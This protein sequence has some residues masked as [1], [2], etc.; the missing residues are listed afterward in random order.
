MTRFARWRRTSST[1]WPTSR[2]RLTLSGGS[3]DSGDGSASTET[4]PSPGRPHSLGIAV[5][6]SVAVVVIDG[7]RRSE[8]TA[9]KEAETNFD[10][11]QRAVEVYLTNVSENTLLKEQDSVDIRTLRRDLLKSA[12]E[13]YKEFADQRKNDPSLRKQ[14]ANAYFRV[15]QLTRE[16]GSAPL[17]IDALRSAQ[18]IWE[19]LVEGQPKRPRAGRPSGRLLPGDRQNPVGARRLPRGHAHARPVA[20]DPGTTGRAPPVRSRLTDR[21]SPTVTSRSASCMP[22]SDQPEESLAIHEKARAIQQDLIS[23]FPDRLSY[24]R[25]LAENINA[26]GYAHYRRLDYDAALRA[27]HAVVDA[28]QSIMKQQT[29]GPNAVWLLNLLAL[30]Q[31]NIGSIHKE[32]GDV[33]KALPALERALGYRV[34]LAEQ[35]PLRDRVPG[36]TRRELPR[37]RRATAQEPTRTPRLSSRVRSQ[38]PSSKTWSGRSP[39]SAGFHAALGIELELRSASFMTKLAGTSRRWPASSTPSRR[40]RLRSTRQKMPICTSESSAI[41]STIS[42]SSTWI[43]AV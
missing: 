17:A 18:A 24:Q 32:M 5:V 35:H 43:W 41:S 21:A 23:R 25:S 4:G 13:Y 8:T 31:Y 36:E 29:H 22:R 26:I 16:I 38:W 3:S 37:D 7:A 42:A 9:R 20:S 27:F 12:L 33:E 34:A 19:P 14:L 11:A 2:W 10:M 6:A 30:G 40:K 28:C 15:G 1:G 39:I